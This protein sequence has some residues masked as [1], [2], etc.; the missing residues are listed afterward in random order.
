MTRSSQKETPLCTSPK[1]PRLICRGEPS[2]PGVYQV[3]PQPPARHADNRSLLLAQSP[4]PISKS[5]NSKPSSWN[6]SNR[7][8]AAAR[9]DIKSR[10]RMKV[11]D[12]RKT[13]SGM[14]KSPVGGTIFSVDS[15]DR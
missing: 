5:S 7:V 2:Y 10:G 13:G 14:R 15:L 4:S 1:L 12:I 11:L 9:C 6:C 8:S 3:L